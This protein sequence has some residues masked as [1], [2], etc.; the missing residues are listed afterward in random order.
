VLNQSLL[1]RFSN[2]VSYIAFLIVIFGGGTYAWIYKPI[3]IVFGLY[4]AWRCYLRRAKITQAGVLHM[5]NVIPWDKI[6][7]VEFD[8]DKLRLYIGSYHMHVYT[9]GIRELTLLYGGFNDVQV[10]SWK[11][12][13][14]GRLID[15]EKSRIA[16]NKGVINRLKTILLWIGSISM[17]IMIAFLVYLS[18]IYLCLIFCMVF[19]ILFIMTSIRLWGL[20][21]SNLWSNLGDVICCFDGNGLTY[22]IKEETYCFEWEAIESIRAMFCLGITFNTIDGRN[23]TVPFIG[24]NII[25]R[26]VD[27]AGFEKKK[28][29]LLAVQYSK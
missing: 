20:Y 5:G 7:K 22:Q 6:E 28:G 12:Q 3:I 11:R 2:I 23:L 8:S 29:T 21:N 17:L 1:S 15:E 10:F 16:C 19:L 14:F 13:N 27:D 26:I 24:Y 18:K 9:Q 4:W 25:A